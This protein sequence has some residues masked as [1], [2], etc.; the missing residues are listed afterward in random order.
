MSSPLERLAR[1]GPRV[2][3]GLM[4]GTSLDGI[5]A[6]IVRIEGTG[7]EVQI[8]TLGF[9][10]EPYDAELRDA[11]GACVEVTTSNVRL[12]S[13]LHAR[14]GDCFADAVE[15]ALAAAGLGLD[16]LDLVGSHGQTVQH[17]PEA[18]EV[19]GVPT[20]STL[21]IG[22]PAVLAV[23]LGAPVVAD[24]RAGDLAL[25]GQAAPLAPF[26]D[27]ALFAAPDETRVLLNLGGIANLTVLPPGGPPRAAFDTGPANMVLDA[28][29]LRL[30][31]QPYDEAGA[32]AAQGTPDDLLVADVLDA[33]F[34]RA[35][36]PKSTGREDFGAPFV[37][38]LV[39]RG[40][41][42]PAD[43]LATAAA[44]TARSIAEAIRRW[45]DPV[46][47]RVIASGGGVHNP[48]LIAMLADEL[49]PIPVETTAAYG[50]D[51]DA[52]EA[53][54]FA[55]LAHEWANGVR[56]GLPAVTG[57]SRPAFQG[58]LTLP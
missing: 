33:P 32:L 18:E 29:A 5:D 53:V 47:D 52:K 35:A 57:A 30:T 2:V 13:Q 12:V 20:R 1:S 22:C 46:P 8:E 51:P 58:S 19:A 54:L 40:P 56:T 43:L 28:L 23:R 50:L 26:L 9:V 6:V 38:W 39:G 21:Q 37:D 55:L 25:G 48:T 11:L 3:A 7:T 44:V 41:A 49:A 10:S 34:F 27:G 42:A 36:P 24:F 45:V 31:G 15:G 14:L 16:A 4:S 17:V